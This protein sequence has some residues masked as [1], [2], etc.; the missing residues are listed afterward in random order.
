[1]LSPHCSE[2][3]FQSAPKDHQL[4]EH[5]PCLKWFGVER[6]DTNINLLLQDAVKI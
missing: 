5:E 6:L 4:D 1:V 3:L 2:D